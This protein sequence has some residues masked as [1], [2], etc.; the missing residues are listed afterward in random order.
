MQLGKFSSDR[1]SALH[2]LCTSDWANGSFGDVEAPTGYVWRISNTWEECKPEAMD[3]TSVLED[4]LEANPEV[5]DTAEFR[6]SLVGHYLVQEGSN[7]L[8][9]VQRFTHESALKARFEQLQEQFSEWLGDS[10]D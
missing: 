1:D 9:H 5:E 10:E 6:R 3:F 7:G 2:Y 4:W 8:V